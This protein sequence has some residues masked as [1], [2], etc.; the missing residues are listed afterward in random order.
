MCDNTM[1]V[2]VTMSLTVSVPASMFV[3]VFLLESCT[4]LPTAVIPRLPRL[5]PRKWGTGSHSNRGGGN[6]DSCLEI[7]IDY[8][9]K[10][11][12]TA[13]MQTISVVLPR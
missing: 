1:F 8:R 5:K 7:S 4:V 9:G 2:S 11:A 13:V 12:V 3:S 6:G 10:A